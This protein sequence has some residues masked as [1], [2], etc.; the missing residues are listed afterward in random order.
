ML[1]KMENLNEITYEII[2]KRYEHKIQDHDNDPLV[3]KVKDTSCLKCYPIDSKEVSVEFTEHFN[4]FW[5]WSWEYLKAKTYNMETLTNF[6]RAIEN[7]KKFYYENMKME[8]DPIVL[9]QLIRN[10]E[11][12]NLEIICD[13]EKIISNVNGFDKR[14]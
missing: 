13:G 8:A 5:E 9:E 6:K 3:Y 10:S 12:I 7:D 1:K 2:T 11:E 14:R 4:L